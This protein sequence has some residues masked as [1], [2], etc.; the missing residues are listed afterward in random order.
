[1]RSG[2]VW[3]ETS[4]TYGIQRRIA[5]CCLPGDTLN[6]LGIFTGFRFN[7]GVSALPNQGLDLIHTDGDVGVAD[8][9]D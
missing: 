3:P 5:E 1:M 9:S 8:D 6:L 2:E 7:L 4:N